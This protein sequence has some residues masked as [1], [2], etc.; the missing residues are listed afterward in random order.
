MPLLNLKRTGV[1]I[2]LSILAACSPSNPPFTGQ[3]IGKPYEING[4][5]YRPEPDSTYD[6]IGDA[7][8]YGPGFDGKRTASGEIFDQDDVTAAHPTLPMPSLVKV[9]N[10]KNNQSVVVRINDR[11]PY[12]D[13]RI[14]DL[15][16]KSAEIIGLKSTQP[17]RVQFLDKETSEYIDSIKGSSPKI[18]MIAYNESYKQKVKEQEGEMSRQMAVAASTA[19]LN[20]AGYNN[21]EVED[22]AP[23][24]SVES[25]DTLQSPNA[26][27]KQPA[28]EKQNN[29][30]IN[31]AMASEKVIY[32]LQPVESP[33]SQ[34]KIQAP[35]QQQPQP[36]PRQML[37][38]P[39]KTEEKPVEKLAE[40]PIE[41]PIAKTDSVIAPGGRFIILAGSFA[42]KEN[43]QKLANSIISVTS[44]SNI[45][46]VDRVALSGKEW[47]CV[48]V[49]PFTNKDTASQTL[50]TVQSLGVPDARILKQ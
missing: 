46:T 11:G 44:N 12:H 39:K 4:K 41:K 5:I 47:W 37:V 21:G 49:G 8:W 32:P 23:I 19:N 13:N 36:Q 34:P 22:F 3:K 6:K 29:F 38:A 7:S 30:L 43:A 9:T 26:P 25:R 24:Q 18:D 31:E 45:A 14:I 17:V 42:S 16:K 28:P 1:F 35:A 48:H 2:A 20:K 15:S 50:Q 10:L 33:L 27:A 40:K